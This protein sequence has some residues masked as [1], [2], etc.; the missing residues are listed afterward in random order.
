MSRQ[1]QIFLQSALT[2]AQGVIPQLELG[3]KWGSVCHTVVAGLQL[4]LGALSQSYNTDGTPQH[5]AYVSPQEATVVNPPEW[6]KT[7]EEKKEK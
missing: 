3:P 1:Y 5:V 6:V 7:A 4:M 2:I